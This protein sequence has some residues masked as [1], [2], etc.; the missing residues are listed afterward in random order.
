MAWLVTFGL[1]NQ[2][3]Y[4]PAWVDDRTFFS[5]VSLDHADILTTYN[6]KIK[7]HNYQEAA[8]YL[9][10]TVEVGNVDMDYNG[11]YLWNHFE[12]MIYNIEQ[13][14]TTRMQKTNIRPYY[15]STAPTENLVERQTVWIV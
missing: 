5:D 2:E 14:A 13:W 12:S 8:Q 6:N 11:A 15:S 7:A 4:Y 9:N 1:H 3:S 10:D